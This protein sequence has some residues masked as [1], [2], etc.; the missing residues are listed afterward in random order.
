MA[1]LLH[2]D[3]LDD[4]DTRRGIGSLNFVMGNKVCVSS[5]VPSMI[6]STC[7]YC[8]IVVGVA[9]FSLFFF[10]WLLCLMQLAVLAGDFLLSRA[11]VALAS[12]KNTEVQ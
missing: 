9:C 3:V 4:A 10:L 2:D 5:C 8:H 7:V 12:L 6:F 1:S 11:C